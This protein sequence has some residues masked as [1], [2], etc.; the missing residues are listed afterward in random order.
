M[1]LQSRYQQVNVPTPSSNVSARSTALPVRPKL[2]PNTA[3]NPILQSQPFVLTSATGRSIS[4][5]VA[6]LLEPNT[7]ECP[8]RT[9]RTYW[10]EISHF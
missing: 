3:T 7:Y 10:A 6:H 2:A 8:K 4:T 5:V 1:M 9:I